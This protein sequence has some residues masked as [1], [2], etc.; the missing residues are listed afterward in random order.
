MANRR[1][2]HLFLILA[3]LAFTCSC[4]K[5]DS[6][7]QII[8]DPVVVTDLVK[9]V[10]WANTGQETYT[11]NPDST[12]KQSVAG[13]IGTMTIV[14]DFQYTNQRLS[15]IIKADMMEETYQYNSKGLVSS[16]TEKMLNLSHPG[17]RLE[18]EYNTNGTVQQMKYFEFDDLGS[19]LKSTTTYEYE[20]QKAKKITTVSAVNPAS[21]VTFEI[22]G[23]SGDV[24]LNPWTF[25]EP[26]HLISDG[27]QLHNYPFL[28]SQHSLPLKVTKKFEI[29]GVVQNTEIENFSYEIKNYRLESILYKSNNFKVSYEY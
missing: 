8:I 1:N 21:K 29:N 3:L 13:S 11:Y 10:K 2:V 22:E 19:N 20:Q 7:E 4:K 23:Y 26:W 14:R 5:D 15:R 12:I 27:F 18:F 25:I 17:S 16:I 28:L 9:T 6:S 24:Y